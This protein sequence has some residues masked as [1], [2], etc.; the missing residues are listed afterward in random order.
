MSK[1]I[2]YTYWQDGDMWLGYLNN[3]PDY[4]SQGVSI[5]EL[6]ENLGDIH[7]DLLKAYSSK[8]R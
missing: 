1:R 4:I 6:K 5:V 2:D 3:Y 8:S 7:K